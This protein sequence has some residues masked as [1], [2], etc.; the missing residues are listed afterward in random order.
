VLV[1]LGRTGEVG[2]RVV[3][4]YVLVKCQSEKNLPLS[5]L[6]FNTIRVG[7][8]TARVH[9]YDNAS[10]FGA[11]EIRKKATEINASEITRLPQR[12]AHGN[13][14][15][16]R[17]AVVDGPTVF[18]DTDVIFWENCEDIVLPEGKLYGGRFIPEMVECGARM[19]ARIH[20]SLLFVPDP[21]ALRAALAPLYKKFWYFKPF[22]GY[23]AVDHGNAVCW[24]VCS[25]LY[26]AL[27]EAAYTFGENEL[28]RYDHL[29]AG[30]YSDRLEDL[31]MDSGTAA[32][33]RSAHAVATGPDW[34]S[35][36]GLWREQMPSGERKKLPT[37][38]YWSG[39]L[40][41]KEADFG[42]MHAI[43]EA[44]GIPAFRHTS[45]VDLG[46][47]KVYAGDTA[48]LHVGIPDLPVPLVPRRHVSAEYHASDTV[49]VSDLALTINGKR[50]EGLS[51]DLWYEREERDVKPGDG[52][53]WISMRLRD[54]RS[55][56]LYDRSGKPPRYAVRT[57]GEW[58][59]VKAS[60]QVSASRWDVTLGEEFFTIVPM[61]P[62][63]EIVDEWRGFR[64]LEAL[65]EVYSGD[66]LVG[67]AYVEVVP[68]ASTALIATPAQ[69]GNLSFSESEMHL[70]WAQGNK[71][72]AFLMDCFGWATQ[73]ADDL[74]D[75]DTE[76]VSTLQKRSLAMSRLL[77]LLLIRIPGNPFFRANE[78]HFV[79]L[80]PVLIA[81]WDASNTWGSA[82]KLE[83]RMFSYVTRAACG[84]LLEQVAY[85]VGGLDWMMQV[86]REI[87]DYYYGES[88]KVES[89]ADWNKEPK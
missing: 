38:H 50:Y 84:R 28:N 6:V 22:Q 85:V 34:R 25:S 42:F 21:I 75:A 64:Y 78:V 40:A 74:A 26:A 20:P 17:V 45:I 29:F 9:V 5:L 67:N 16:E 13:F 55:I 1:A 59:P 24:D 86:T 89:F 11:A 27:L 31:N 51:G 58:E 15:A 76:N 46:T 69:Q 52:W 41:S 57:D 66:A 33:I 32:R 47:K 10:D 80:F 65:C 53:R 43:F 39:T 63:Q 73:L 68:S 54:G 14:I 49:A 60:V 3:N 8:P 18:V 7:F 61:L 56:M 12:V 48:R 77:Y 23:T 44:P 30:T 4:V 35:L 88:G 82:R 70:R 81:Q 36:R 37:W 71:D 2:S 79:G 87:H 72:A 83:T 19:P 62:D